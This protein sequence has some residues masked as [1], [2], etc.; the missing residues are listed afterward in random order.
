MRVIFF[1]IEKLE[2]RYSSQWY[3]WFMNEFDKNKVEV[4]DIYP[5]PLSA[6]IRD[7]SFLD[8]CGTNY[9][10]SLQIADFSKK[11]FNHKIK[12]DDVLFFMDAW[13]PGLEAVAYIR[14]A[15][16]LNFK[17]CGIFHAGT[18]DCNDFTAKTGM[19][20]WGKC[21]EESWF[22]I[23]DKIFVATKYH[24]DLLITTRDVDPN[25]IVV[26][27]LPTTLD[28]EF[29]PLG[30]KSNSVVFPHR[31]DKEKNPDMFYR[32]VKELSEE[33]HSEKKDWTFYFSKKECH[34]KE[35]YYDLLQDS[36]ISVSFADQETFGIAMIE[37]VMSGC[38]PV[39]PNKL[40]YTELYD[41]MFC[42]SSFNEAKQIIKEIMNFPYK[43]ERAFEN[44]INHLSIVTSRAIPNM[45]NEMKNMV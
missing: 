25:K 36:K 39:V 18:Y 16:K 22:R 44:T 33:L 7:G 29:V 37:S 21:L 6:I 1:P 24:K 19:G 4:I 20:Y 31:M 10:K 2:E 9:F 13:F 41:P 23:M 27:G 34:T 35:E 42:F 32:L 43:F 5:E 14:D 26:T 38:Y 12:N 17:I 3:K 45:I 30:L 40:S 11:A 15:L 28:L 8:V